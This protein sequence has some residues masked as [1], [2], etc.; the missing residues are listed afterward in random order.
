M[1]NWCYL[2]IHDGQAELHDACHLVGLDTWE[3]D[4]KRAI[5]HELGFARAGLACTASE[6]FIP[7]GVMR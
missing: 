1:G 5:A 6:E 7:E 3:V 4:A 2:F